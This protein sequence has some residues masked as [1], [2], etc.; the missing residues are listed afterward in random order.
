MSHSLYKLLSDL[1]NARIHFT[2][3]RYRFET[4]L[5]SITVPG[6]RIEVDVFEDGHMEVSRFPG[7]EGIQGGAELVSQLIETYRD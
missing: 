7:S 2:L 4:V 1:E 3:G 6:E 5:V